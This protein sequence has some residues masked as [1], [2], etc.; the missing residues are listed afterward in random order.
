MIEGQGVPYIGCAWTSVAVMGFN[1]FG[2]GLGRKKAS[3][4]FFL[5]G[6]HSSIT[7]VHSSEESW[8]LGDVTL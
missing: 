4:C 8:G 2:R 1:G 5:P 6:N 3:G 7:L